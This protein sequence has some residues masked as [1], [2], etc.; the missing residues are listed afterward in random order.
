PARKVSVRR[1]D[2]DR[3]RSMLVLRLRDSESDGDGDASEGEGLRQSDLVDWYLAQREDAMQSED[4]FAHE[5]RLVKTVLKY[6]IGVEGCIIALRNAPDQ[7]QDQEQ[8]QEKDVEA[9]EERGPLLMLHPNFAI[10]S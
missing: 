4:D 6:L 2:F 7:D 5:Q 9:N 3:V 8:Q 1:E 10:E